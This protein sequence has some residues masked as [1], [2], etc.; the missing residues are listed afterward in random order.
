MFETKV[1]E[2]NQKPLLMLKNLF[3][4][5]SYRLWDNIEK[6]C[7]DGRATDG[8]MAHAHCMLD[9]QGYQHTLRICNTH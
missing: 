5:K 4:R 1:V 6:F 3:L 2:K 8:N 7:R 9:T